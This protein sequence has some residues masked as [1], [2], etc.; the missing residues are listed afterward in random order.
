MS[1]SLFP[2]KVVEREVLKDLVFGKVHPKSVKISGSADIDLS[3]VD[4]YQELK[5]R[6]RYGF[7]RLISEW[8]SKC[9]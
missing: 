3:V 8:F 4:S 5:G 2:I 1:K 6:P 7:V 9:C